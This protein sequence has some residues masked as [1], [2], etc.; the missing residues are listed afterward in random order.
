MTVTDEPPGPTAEHQRGP[1]L[2]LRMHTRLHANPISAAA[3]KVVV[4]FIG[5]GVF[6]AGVI[7]LVIPGPGLVAMALGLAILATEWHWARRA[8]RWMKEKAL[9]AAERTGPTP[10]KRRRR[11]IGTSVAGIIVVVVVVG[12]VALFDWPTF[13]VVGWDWV[14]ELHSAIP[15]LP[16]M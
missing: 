1:H 11:I 5:V 6:V 14:Q 7:M 3:T 16:G 9:A 2:F 10:E 8:T 13:A 4:T 15:E 12:Y